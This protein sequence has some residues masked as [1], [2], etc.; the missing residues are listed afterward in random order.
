MKQETVP[1]TPHGTREAILRESLRLINEQGM[2]DFRIDA[3]ATSLSLSPGNITYHF[4]R[5]EDICSALWETYIEE[6]S[7]VSVTLTSLLDLKQVFLM[8]RSNMI[9]S[10]QFR[11]VLIF[12]SADFGAM[13][14]DKAINAINLKNHNDISEASYR[15]LSTNG[16]LLPYEGNED[17]YKIVTS[18]HYLMMRWVMNLAYQI[19][20]EEEIK[21]KADRYALLCLYTVYPLLTDKGRK[22]FMEI[23]QL[24]EDDNI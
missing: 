15:L 10:H 8:N 13:C 23:A 22:E 19:Y 21:S 9:L 7:K 12:R 24:V 4:S 14:R 11:G 6:Y 2:I 17:G 3:L 16:Y 18:N 5:K 20:T 1:V